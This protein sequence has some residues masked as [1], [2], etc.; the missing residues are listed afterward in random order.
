VSGESKDGAA[1]TFRL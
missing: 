1:Y